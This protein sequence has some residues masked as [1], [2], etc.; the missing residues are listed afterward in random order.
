MCSVG[1]A[2]SL[3]FALLP[4]AVCCIMANILLFFPGGEIQYVQQERLSRL[5]WFMMGIGGGGV[6]MFL[7]AG[8]FISLGKCTG[9]CWNESFMMCG[10]VMAALVGLAGSGYCFIIS[11]MAMLEGPQCF[12]ALGW[13]YPFANEG[14]RYLMEKDTWSN[15]LQPVSIV[16][17]NVTL[18]SILLGLSGL[19][20]IICVLQVINGLVTAVCRPCCYKQ[21]YTLNA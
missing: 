2:R 13:S 21:D 6:L 11:A 12:T 20:F 1:F 15:C 3:G 16:E 18:M 4:L 8:V 7:P 17:W 10:S 19:E 14:G 9:C 5:I